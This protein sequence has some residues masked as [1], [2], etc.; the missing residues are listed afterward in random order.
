MALGIP[1]L[2]IGLPSNLSPF[3]DA[4]VMAGADGTETSIREGLRGVLY[5]QE[6][7]RQLLSRTEIFLGRHGMRPSGRAAE[8]AADVIVEAGSRS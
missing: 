2:V 7:R 4:G 6:I 1:A 5:D 8:R 3:V